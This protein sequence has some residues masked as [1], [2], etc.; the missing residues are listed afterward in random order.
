MA[1]RRKKAG[2]NSGKRFVDGWVEF[3]SKKVARWIAEAYNAKPMGGPKRNRYAEDLWT[4]K[5][6]KGFKWS[7][8]TEKIGLLTI[9]RARAGIL[10][11]RRRAFE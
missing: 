9:Q 3:E 5:Y 6:L 7:H 11:V 8:L 4:L 1:R 2:G 10:S